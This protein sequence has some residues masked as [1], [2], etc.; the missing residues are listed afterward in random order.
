MLTCGTYGGAGDFAYLEEYEGCGVYYA[1]TPF[2]LRMCRQAP[3]VIVGGGNS[4]GQAALYLARYASSVRMLV[5]GADLSESM[6]RYLVDAIG[7][8]PSIEIMF[9]GGCRRAG[10][11]G[12]RHHG[13]RLVARGGPP[14]GDGAAG[15]VRRGRRSQRVDQTGRVRGRGGRHGGTPCA[16]MVHQDREST[17]RM[18]RPHRQR[19]P[20]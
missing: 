19:G 11:P 9:H 16:R 13:Q 8:T 17:G 14:P 6:S 10:R 20:G 7:R 12:L 1:A 4:A 15:R 5:R 2:E 18:T 3:V